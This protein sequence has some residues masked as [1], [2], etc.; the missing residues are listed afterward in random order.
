MSSK[1]NDKRKYQSKSNS[2]KSNSMKS[3]VSS[4]SRSSKSNS[5]STRKKENIL[6]KQHQKVVIMLIH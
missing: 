1:I 2:M 4:I 5:K 6:Q 3:R